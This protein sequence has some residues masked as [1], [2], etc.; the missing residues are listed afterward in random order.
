MVYADYDPI[1]VARSRDLLEEH[2]DTRR[3]AAIDLQAVADQC[4]AG[5]VDQACTRAVKLSAEANAE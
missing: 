1:A 4:W 2:G 3:H 5:V